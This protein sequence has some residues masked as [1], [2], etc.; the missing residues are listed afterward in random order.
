[1]TSIVHYELFCSDFFVRNDLFPFPTVLFQTGV[2]SPSFYSDRA[3]T[4]W[5]LWEG[6]RGNWSLRPNETCMLV[7]YLL[8]MEWTRTRPFFSLSWQGARQNN[9][10]FLNPVADHAKWGPKYVV[11]WDIYFPWDRVS[12][13][14]SYIGCGQV[15][16][17]GTI[18]DVKDGQPLPEA[19]S[20]IPLSVGLMH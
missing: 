18:N 13:W 1:M 4:S 7:I 11:D 15:T 2:N 3:F 6:E 16:N 20:P 19:V 12:F 14:D 8:C 10:R 9:F 5:E 17:E